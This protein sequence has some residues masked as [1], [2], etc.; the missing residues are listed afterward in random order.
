MLADPAPRKIT[1]DICKT[2]CIM[3][4]SLLFIMFAS[5]LLWGATAP[6]EYD[7]TVSSH[8][9][10]KEQDAVTSA[11]SEVDPL[12]VIGANESRTTKSF[13]HSI[14]YIYEHEK[15]STT[16][17]I[18]TAEHIQTMCEIEVRGQRV[19]GLLGFL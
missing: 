18:T 19:S 15:K 16:S 4:G 11:F 7:W 6:G 10:S 13:I 9:Y 8:R 14:F 3:L 1:E 2:F 17:T 5:F 12:V